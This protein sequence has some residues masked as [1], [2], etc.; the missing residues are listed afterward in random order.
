MFISGEK[1]VFNIR[2]ISALKSSVTTSCV[3]DPQAMGYANQQI[4]R[5]LHDLQIRHLELLQDGS[6]YNI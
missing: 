5:E 2:L 1:R 3:D 6:E 4:F